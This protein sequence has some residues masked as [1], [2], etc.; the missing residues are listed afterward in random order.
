MANLWKATERET[1]DVDLKQQSWHELENSCISPYKWVWRYLLLS[2]QFSFRVIVD[3]IKLQFINCHVITVSTM[4]QFGFAQQRDFNFIDPHLYSRFIQIHFFA[5]F[6]LLFRYCACIQQWFFS[7]A[8][9]FFLAVI[10]SKERLHIYLKLKKTARDLEKKVTLLW[11]NFK[12]DR[13]INFDL[14]LLG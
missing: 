9:N 10:N 3:F 12:Y 7:V 2:R 1:N 8:R 13:F 14:I 5:L 6:A 4:E 11:A